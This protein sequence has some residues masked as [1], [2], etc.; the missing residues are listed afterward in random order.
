[1][2]YEKLGVLVSLIIFLSVGMFFFV[3]HVYRQDGWKGIL[4]IPL[5]IVG[6]V[7]AGTVISGVVIGVGYLISLFIC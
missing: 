7:T 2:G 1:M 4:M 5:I 3:R 6:G